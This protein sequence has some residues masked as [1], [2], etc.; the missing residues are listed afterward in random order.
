[1]RFS[2][3]ASFHPHQPD[4]HA[5]AFDAGALRSR[6]GGA[7][8]DLLHGPEVENIFAGAARLAPGVRATGSLDIIISLR[9]FVLRD[10]S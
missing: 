4:D 9:L 7:T 5:V 6:I 3:G 10:V 1:M 2:A 8:H